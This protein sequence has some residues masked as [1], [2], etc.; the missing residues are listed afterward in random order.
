MTAQI[1]RFD[2]NDA[3]ND[4]DPVVGL[5]RMAND[6]RNRQSSEKPESS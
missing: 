3:V 2:D 1:L 5:W 6:A 4:E